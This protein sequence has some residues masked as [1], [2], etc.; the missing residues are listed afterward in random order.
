MRSKAETGTNNWVAGSIRLIENAQQGGFGQ[1]WG[2]VQHER[3]GWVWMWM[4]IA[5]GTTGR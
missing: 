1:G 5:G 2:K 4:S 3:Q